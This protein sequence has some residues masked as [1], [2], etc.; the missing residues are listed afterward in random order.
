MTTP[1]GHSSAT[2]ALM[3]L[4]P[5]TVEAY[6]KAV[7][8]FTAWAKERGI[9]VAK[10][11][12]AALD[13]AASDY[14]VDLFKA[15]GVGKQV[16]ANL[17]NGIAFFHPEAK[18]HLGR[19]DRSI[20]GW[21]KAAPPEAGKPIVREVAANIAVWLA[22]HGKK[23]MAIALL[24]SY[25][26]LLRAGEMLALKAENV[27]FA[28]SYLHDRKDR[29]PASLALPKTKTGP[30]RF[31]E[32]H[33]KPVADLLRRHLTEKNIGKGHKVFDFTAGTYRKWFKK[34]I[35]ALGYSDLTPHGLRHGMATDMLFDGKLMQDVQKAGR[36]ASGRSADHY[37]QSGRA[38]SLKATHPS[39]TL[40]R[41]G[42]FFWNSIGRSIARA[43]A[44]AARSSR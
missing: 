32:V 26:A 11:D 19:L 25:S 24:V 37:V 31:A 16:A 41:L 17:R 1:A 40:E 36:W 4:A 28:D 7:T 5:A 10:G 43:A 29:K 12:Y 39:P 6:A 15:S 18:L 42:L 23:D 22:R 27:V 33:H 34:A 35:T 8:A 2:L 3:S 30:N 21:R 44:R 38:L 20:A 14:C 13:V 9:K